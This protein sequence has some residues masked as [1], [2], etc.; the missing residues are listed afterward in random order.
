V[1]SRPELPIRLGFKEIKEYQYLVLHEIPKPIIEHDIAAY[2]EYE[3]ARIRNDYNDSVGQDRQLPSDWPGQ[4][5]ANV[6]VDMAVPLFIFAATVC[7]FIKDRRWGSPEQQLA[8]ILK[9]QTKSQKSKLDATYL[10]ILN[11]LL[12]GLPD[13][14]KQDLVDEFR[15]VVGPIVLLAE[16]LSTSSLACLLSIDKVVIDCRLDLLHS[17]LSIPSD[18]DSP[19]RLLHLSF[20][21]FLVDSDKRDTNLFWVDKRGTHERIAIS[22]LQLLDSSGHL[23]KDICN[24]KLPGTPRAIVESGAI[25]K[26]LPADVR[27]ACLYWVHHFEQSNVR[28]T[29]DHQAHLFLKRHF[30]HWLEALSLMGKISE[31]IGMINTLQGLLKVGYSEIN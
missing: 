25:D 3:L 30:L 11:Q 16:P 26:S 12:A 17:V 15:S 6:L 13:S 31:S 23:R 18:A 28:I 14:E 5:I 20:R 1:T 24:L 9:Y 7:R 8:K 22:C 2:L 10:P 4:A 19:V 29:D 21:D 27:Y